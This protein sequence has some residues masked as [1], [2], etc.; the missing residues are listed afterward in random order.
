M[1]GCGHSAWRCDLRSL[2]NNRHGWCPDEDTHG[3]GVLRAR[4]GFRNTMEA[5][6]LGQSREQHVCRKSSRCMR[7]LQQ[8]TKAINTKTDLCT[9]LST[10][11]PHYLHLRSQPRPFLN[12]HTKCNIHSGPFYAVWVPTRCS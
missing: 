11:C 10:G 2:W 4:L 1:N 9:P 3:G 6:G 5:F 7:S 8:D 12:T